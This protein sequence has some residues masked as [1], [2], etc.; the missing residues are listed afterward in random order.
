LKLQSPFAKKLSF[1]D[2]IFSKVQFLGWRYL[3]SVLLAFSTISFLP[4]PSKHQF[5]NYVKNI[6][7]EP[8]YFWEDQAGDWN[9]DGTRQHYLCEG[10]NILVVLPSQTDGYYDLQ[11]KTLDNEWERIFSWDA[12]LKRYLPS[13]RTAILN[14]VLAETL[15][16]RGQRF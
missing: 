15:N 6:F 16:L 7:A 8:I 14:R 1:L 11:V 3:I 9:K 2:S 13:D 12:S 5:L 4:L 10:E